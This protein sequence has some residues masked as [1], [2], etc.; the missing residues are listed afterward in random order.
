MRVAGA[1]CGSAQ[2]VT[3]MRIGS[4]GWFGFTFYE[5]LGECFVE[6]YHSDDDDRGDKRDMIPTQPGK[7]RRH[8]FLPPGFSNKG[9]AE[10]CDHNTAAESPTVVA[11]ESDYRYRHSQRDNA[12]ASEMLPGIR[13]ALFHLL[14]N[15][16]GEPRPQLA[17]SVQ[18]HGS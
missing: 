12:P 4:D 10:N 5:S 1:I 6:Q 8:I 9:Q 13:D 3:D 16:T 11:D 18:Q 17:R 7:I 14:P 2:I 15:V